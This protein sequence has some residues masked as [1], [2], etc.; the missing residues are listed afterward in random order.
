MITLSLLHPQN[1]KPIQYWTFEEKQDIIRIGRSTD[2]DVV[3]YSAVVSRHHLEIHKGV[4]GWAIQSLGTNGTYLDGKRIK[5]VTAED[6]LVV[7]LARSGP[8]LKITIEQPEKSSAASIKELL[9]RRK[10]PQ[11]GH[12]LP[13]QSVGTDLDVIKTDIRDTTSHKTNP[14]PM[15]NGNGLA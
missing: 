6:G 9:A 7:R 1:K 13:E 8:N 3:L 5:N 15:D 12:S 11:V 2:N 14:D 10:Q 4:E